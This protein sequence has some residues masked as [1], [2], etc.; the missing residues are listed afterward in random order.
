MPRTF[1]ERITAS[2]VV[3]LTTV[4]ALGAILVIA[5]GIF[6][7]D[8]FPPFVEKILYFIGASTLVIILAAVL[9]NI[10][11]NLSRLAEYAG[12]ILQESRQK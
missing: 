6:N 5:N 9:I 10:M 2:L 8:I 3:T 4:L 12:Q 1:L 7:W 11:I